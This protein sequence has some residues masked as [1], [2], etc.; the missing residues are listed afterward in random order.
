MLFRNRK[1][2]K[3]DEIYKKGTAEGLLQGY[4]QAKQEMEGRVRELELKVESLDIELKTAQ[5]HIN[6]LGRLNKLTKEEG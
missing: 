1:N 4:L 6:L 2:S 5:D 3:M